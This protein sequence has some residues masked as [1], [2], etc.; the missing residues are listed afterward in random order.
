LIAAGAATALESL[1]VSRAA[2][3][4]DPPDDEA[5]AILSGFGAGSLRAV[6]PAPDPLGVELPSSAD[7]ELDVPVPAPNEATPV[8]TS[9]PGSAMK[10]T[11]SAISVLPGVIKTKKA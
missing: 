4:D 11:R 5:A 9:A 6:G 10:A 3:A 7:R 1:E 2:D 8:H